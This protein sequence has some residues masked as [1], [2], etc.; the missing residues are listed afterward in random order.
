MK[1]IKLESRNLVQQKITEALRLSCDEIRKSLPECSS[2]LF[3]CLQCEQKL[4]SRQKC[5]YC[6]TKE[7]IVPDNQVSRRYLNLQNKS[8]HIQAFLKKSI[9]PI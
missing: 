2:N 3:L 9:N 6:Q 4:D 1:G 7:F 5:F 8:D